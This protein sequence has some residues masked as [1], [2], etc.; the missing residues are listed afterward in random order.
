VFVLVN[1]SRNTFSQPAAFNWAS[2]LDR[3]CASVETR[4]SVNHARILH[5]N[6]ASEKSNRISALVLI[7]IS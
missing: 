6:F 4:A 3:S 5:Q 7:R 2:W 1:F